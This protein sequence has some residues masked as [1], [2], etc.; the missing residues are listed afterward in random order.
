MNDTSSTGNNFVKKEIKRCNRNIL[1]S[2]IGLLL[3]PAAIFTIGGRYWYNFVFGPFPITV[4]EL[5]EIQEPSQSL[6]YFVTVNGEQSVDTGFEQITQRKRGGTI[7]SSSVSAKVLALK[8]ENKILLVKANLSE[9]QATSFTGRL[10]KIPDKIQIELI[11]NPEIKEIKDL[12]LPFLLSTDTRDHFRVSGYVYLVTAFA[13]IAISFWN[14][15]KLGLQQGKLE[16]H[17]LGKRLV[18]FGDFDVIT[19]QINSQVAICSNNFVLGKKLIITN[20]WLIQRKFYHIDLLQLEQIVWAYQKVT[21]HKTNG[22]LTGTNYSALVINKSGKNLEIPA[23]RE[24]E[25][26]AIITEIVKRIP[27]IIVG[28][29]DDLQKTWQKDKALFCAIVQQRRQQGKM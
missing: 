6:K 25:V 1:I 23:T 26:K 7:V 27:W 17:P 16:L 11:N 22:V 5:Q 13:C 20:S 12:F 9:Q 18:E 21:R 10:T 2:N 4:A 29:T 14:L 24:E 19:N 28:Y 15:I 3:I 8:V